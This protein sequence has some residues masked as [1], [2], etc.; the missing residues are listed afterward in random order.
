MRNLLTALSIL[1]VGFLMAYAIGTMKPK[2]LKTASA[3]LPAIQAQAIKVKPKT[4][5]I[6]VLSHGLVE[7]GLGIDIISE[8][9]GR[10]IAVHNNFVNGGR[11]DRK[12]IIVR[13]DDT[14]Y[15]SE[16]ANVQADLASAEETLS[17]EKARAN[18]AKKEWRDLGSEDANALFL[19][20]PQL[21]SAQAKLNAVKARL[22]LA[23]QKLARTRLTLPYDSNIVETHI[24]VGQYLTAG[25]KIA[26]VYHSDKRQVKL[27][28]SQQQLKTAGISWPISKD[29]ALS[30]TI[31]DPRTP[32]LSINAELL[33]R[34]ST[35]DK[36]NQ[37]I[38][39]L[40]KLA[41]EH[42]DSFLPGLYVEANVSGK[43]QEHILSLPEDAFH[44]KRFLLA[45]DENSKITF[46][47]AT[48]LSRE[49]QNIKVSAEIEAG[50]TVITSRLP[51]ATP[52]L[53]I[54]PLFDQ[55][56]L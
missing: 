33:S 31:F 41:P 18:Q 20:K 46:I 6:S 39:L 43:P 47:P 26:R 54:S 10:V 1:V 35:V 24:D 40:V 36:K 42:A 32:Q 15:Q 14:L 12:Q 48:F 45:L 56:R 51:L 21:K 16:L 52:G 19:R 49:G 23:K 44:D 25:T 37:L 38:E 30:V 8:V 28:L 22:A 5:T 29:D 53:E 7:A 3:T 13:I 17:T 4:Q 9:S 34:G 11:I 55:N 50:T 2:P 27:Q